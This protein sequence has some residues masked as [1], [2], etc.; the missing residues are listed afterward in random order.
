MYLVGRNETHASRI[1]EELRSLNPDGKVSFIKSDVSL[2]RNVDEACE[3]IKKR[4]DKVNLLFMSCGFLSTKGRDGEFL[5][6]FLFLFFF[7]I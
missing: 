3:D 6:F 2:L 4:E 1:I 7:C 5:F